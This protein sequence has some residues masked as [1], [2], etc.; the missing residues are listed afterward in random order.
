MSRVGKRASPVRFSRAGPLVLTVEES[1]STL[2]VRVAGDLD[3]ATAGKVSAALD[4][5]DIGRTTRLVLDLQELAFLDLAGLRT[6]LAANQHCRNHQI[7]FVVIKPHGLASRIF[8]LTNVH[9]EVDLVDSRAL[10]HSIDTG[11][12]SARGPGR[13]T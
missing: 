1:D 8:T 2:L 4:R 6:I 10:G 11:D 3:L 7:R 13:S 5:V 9:R 12:G